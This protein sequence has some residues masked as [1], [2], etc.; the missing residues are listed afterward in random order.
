MHPVLSMANWLH[1][2]QASR[3]AGRP[4]F[5]LPYPGGTWIEEKRRNQKLLTLMELAWK[6]AVLGFKVKKGTK[7]TAEENKLVDEIAQ[8]L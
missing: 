1:N 6:T 7:L 2:S 3:E 5:D 4:V 8:H